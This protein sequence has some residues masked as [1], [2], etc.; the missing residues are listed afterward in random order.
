LDPDHAGARKALEQRQDAWAREQAEERQRRERQ[1]AVEAALKKAE[2]T[3]SHEAAIAVLRG[4]VE[5]DPNHA[6]ARKTLEQRQA[7]LDRDR[8]QTW[9]DRPTLVGNAADETILAPRPQAAMGQ[10][11]DDTLAAASQRQPL[12]SQAPTIVANAPTE[13]MPIDRLVS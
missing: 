2:R 11:S 10:G 4:A 7:A 8:E 1:A 5:L 12:D 6:G 3:A 9:R 13:W